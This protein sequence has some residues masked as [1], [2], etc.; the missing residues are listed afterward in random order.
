MSGQNALGLGGDLP[1]DAAS[2]TMTNS[3]SYVVNTLFL[4]F[5]FTEPVS[6][7]FGCSC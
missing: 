5:F 7:G 3:N 4:I 1:N 6:S 2:P